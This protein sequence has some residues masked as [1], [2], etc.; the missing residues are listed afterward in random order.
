MFNNQNPKTPWYDRRVRLAM[1]Y[2]VD[3][4]SIIKN[5]LYGIPHRYAFLAP[6]ELGYDPNLKPYPY[7]PKRARELLAEA[8][9]P[10]GFE[11]KLYWPV[12]GANPM[13]REGVEA[14]ASYFEAVGLRTRLVGEERLAFERRYAA[15]NGPEAEYVCY[16]GC[17]MAGAPEPTQNMFFFFGKTGR[18]TV[19]S[20]PEFDKIIVE[21]KATVD[22]AKRAELI[23]KGVRV[24]YDD[25]DAFSI[26]NTVTVYAMKKNIDFTPT[27][28]IEFDLVLVKDVTIR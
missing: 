26:F 13:L 15:S 1:A 4:D 2:A 14:V 19:C 24:L 10:N 23:K 12:G 7:N 25:V 3:C 9:Y 16:R 18:F 6:H 28:K 11:F 20:N 8:G 17:G 21:A 22:D 27:Q 5:V